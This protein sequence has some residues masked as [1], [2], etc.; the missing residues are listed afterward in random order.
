MT[1]IAPGE[2]LV[3]RD[4][5][6]RPSLAGAAAGVEISLAHAGGA[7][8]VGR[9]VR[10]GLDLEPLADIRASDIDVAL[11]DGERRALVRLDP[12]AMTR[13]V[14]ELWT[15]KEAYAKLD[16]RGLEP[17]L[18]PPDRPGATGA[19]DGCPSCPAAGRRARCPWPRGGTSAPGIEKRAPGTPAL[20][21][22]PEP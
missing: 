10:I 7:V 14:L 19:A 9:G 22:S 3:E 6:G 18:C 12:G 16:G 11:T 8:A 1:G 21:C 15:L 13:R 2:V 4:A 20:D 5:H 17:G